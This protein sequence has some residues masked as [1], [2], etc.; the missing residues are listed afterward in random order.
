MTYPHDDRALQANRAAV[1]VMDAPRATRRLA[2]LLDRVGVA[3]LTGAAV[4]LPAAFVSTL[5]W[6][7]ELTLAGIGLLAGTVGAF[8]LARAWD[9]ALFF[10]EVETW[11]NP[12]MMRR[13]GEGAAIATTSDAAPAP[14]RVLDPAPMTSVAVPIAPPARPGVP[15]VRRN[16]P[17]APR[18]GHAFAA[19]SRRNAPYIQRQPPQQ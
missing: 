3:T 15:Q 14:A 4:A 9:L 1:P 7:D 12:A 18:P 13:L 17:L 10:A 11:Q 19:R 16:H 2:R 5:P 6:Q 8:I